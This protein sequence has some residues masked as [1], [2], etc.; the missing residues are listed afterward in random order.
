MNF[1]PS[2]LNNCYEKSAA[3]HG[4][5]LQR[6]EKFHF[7]FNNNSLYDRTS[8]ANGKTYSINEFYLTG[9]RNESEAASKNSC[10]KRRAERSIEYFRRHLEEKLNTSSS[11]DKISSAVGISS[12]EE[13][14]NSR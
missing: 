11:L 14:R 1:N 10:L 2:T 5:H 6:K 9:N 7:Q 4:F 13:I 8:S 12:E 3:L